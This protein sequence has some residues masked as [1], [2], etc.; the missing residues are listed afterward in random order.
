M[1]LPKRSKICN[2]IQE[3][4][5]EAFKNFTHRIC[6]IVTYHVR[7]FVPCNKCAP[8]IAA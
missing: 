5:G 7:A 6:A 2:A 1:T 3:K 4:G 8:L